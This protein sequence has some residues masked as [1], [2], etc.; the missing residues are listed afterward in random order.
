V[1]FEA[2]HSAWIDE[3]TERV[4]ENKPELGMPVRSRG[5][6]LPPS[7][8]EENCVRFSVQLGQS[9]GIAALAI[10]FE[11]GK[12]QGFSLT[13]CWQRLLRRAEPEFK[14]RG[15][16][17]VFAALAPGASAI[18]LTRFVWVPLK[19]DVGVCFLG[20]GA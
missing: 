5:F 9:Q 10:C 13:D 6:V 15:I 14:R 12:E 19:M 20:L 1:L 3:W 2:L 17:P 8:T 16:R 4:T 18:H 7:V 11:Q